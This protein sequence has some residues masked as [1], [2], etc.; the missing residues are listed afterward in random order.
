MIAL[1]KETQD[2]TWKAQESFWDSAALLCLD[3]CT[4]PTGVCNWRTF[5]ELD[6]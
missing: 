5:I 2:E 6:A 3:P 1:G 4:Y